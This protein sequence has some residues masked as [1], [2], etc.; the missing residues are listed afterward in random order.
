VD[1]YAWLL[2]R[3]YAEVSA[4]KLV[5]DHHGLN[6]RQR[7]AIRRGT[8]ADQALYERRRKRVEPQQLAGRPLAIDGYNLL[9]T[10]EAALSGGLVFVGR[11]GCYRDLA[12]VHGTYRKVEETIPAVDLITAYIHE[13]A[14]ADVTFLLDRPV[15]NSGRLRGLIE[16]RV[17]AAASEGHAQPTWTVELADRPDAELATFVGVVATSDSVILDRCAAWMNLAAHVI[18]KKLPNTRLIDLRTLHRS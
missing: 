12:S 13:L 8:C 18:Q 7:L 5:G 16:D 17:A 11:D 9:I 14:T 10:I 4:L 2:T 1:E 3:G 6:T 15:A